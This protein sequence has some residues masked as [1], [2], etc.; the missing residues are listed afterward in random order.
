MDLESDNSTMESMGDNDVNVPDAVDNAAN[1]ETNGSCSVRELNSNGTVYPEPLADTFV[2]GL[3]EGV[4]DKLNFEDHASSDKLPVA[5]SDSHHHEPNRLTFDDHLD[6]DMSADHTGKEAAENI[7][8]NDKTLS[9]K[10]ASPGVT[11][12]T[13]GRGLKKWKR[14][15][16]SPPMD[17]SPVLDVNKI[18]KR[19]LPFPGDSGKPLPGSSDMK[20]KSEEG[21]VSSTNAVLKSPRAVDTFV[22][23]GSSVLSYAAAFSAGT[24]SDNSE[25]RSSKSS[26]AAS[27]PKSRYD[28]ARTS[29]N[30]DKHKIKNLGGKNM[31][32][33]AQRQSKGQV[34]ASKKHRGEKVNIEKENSV[35]SLDSDSRSYNSV[36]IRGTSFI[37]NFEAQRGTMNGDGEHSFNSVA[38]GQQAVADGLDESIRG[39]DDLIKDDARSSGVV[40]EDK[41][42]SNQHSKEWDPLVDS[43]G[44]LQSAQ[45]AL[46]REIQKFGDIGKDLLTFCDDSKK[47]SCKSPSVDSQIFRDGKSDSWDSEGTGDTPDTLKA[48]V[49]NLTAT[50]KTLEE[51]LEDTR[52]M[53]Q[54]RE[55]KVVE[56]EAAIDSCKLSEGNLVSTMELQQDRC[57]VIQKE[58]EDLFR[59]RVEVEVEYLAIRKEID[60]LSTVARDQ[61][62]LLAVQKNVANEQAEMLKTIGDVEIRLK[63][64]AQELETYS[65]E[66]SGVEVK[67]LQRRMVKFSS[68]LFVQVIL[69]VM[70]LDLFVSQL[71]PESGAVMPT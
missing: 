10:I 42:H 57:Q 3:T 29:V 23:P 7:E 55:S 70:V 33:A 62:K 53:L 51:Q 12:T 68:C 38:G 30:R 27:V 13:K 65:T 34:D 58:L 47:T 44:M 2:N 18:L 25:D 54:E 35:S 45:D 60:Q 8:H 26:T 52:G 5:D 16:R 22:I 28:L 64:Q 67:K 69:L 61:V 39:V 41:R 50:V 43:I 21:S 24:D 11:P 37:P 40:K 6:G 9:P 32:S 4:A 17:G 63:G 59:R 36:F 19:G 20:Q 71:S 49:M 48:E 56:L 15:K 1:I 46:E 31:N 14:Y 66:I